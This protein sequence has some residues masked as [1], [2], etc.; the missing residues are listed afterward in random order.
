M[1]FLNKIF[2][3]FNRSKSASK[4]SSKADELVGLWENDLDDGSGLHAIWGWSYQF[5]ENGSGTYYYWDAQAL[6]DEIE[7]SWSRLSPTCIKM[8]FSA[9]ERWT[10]IEYTIKIVDAP[11]SGKLRKLT[12]NNYVPNDFSSEGFGKAPGAIFKAI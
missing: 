10:V 3:S 9:S 1:K 12:D 7:F 5:N 2:Q 6:Q 8:K 11:Y 4:N